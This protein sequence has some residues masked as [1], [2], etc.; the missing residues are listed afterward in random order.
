MQ[1]RQ[2]GRVRTVGL[3]AHLAA[4]DR[5]AAALSVENLSLGGALLRTGTSLRKGTPLGVQLFCPGRPAALILGAR[6][7]CTRRLDAHSAR[8]ASGLAVCFESLNPEQE[9]WLRKLLLSFAPGPAVLSG[10]LPTPTRRFAT[11]V[12]SPALG[13]PGSALETPRLATALFGRTGQDL[14][15]APAA[16]PVAGP[17]PPPPTA[18]DPGPEVH[19]LMVQVKGLLMQ[20]SESQLRADSLEREGISLRR[21]NQ[22]LKAA[23]V[24]LSGGA[25][26]AHVG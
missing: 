6:V 17:P 1:R 26:S 9:G 24:A 16:Q 11:P 3:T 25:G 19:R 18:A 8:E 23:L 7:V 22:R 20:L 21:E 10:D 4:P 12:A 13:A 5:V 14:G 15:L 2:H